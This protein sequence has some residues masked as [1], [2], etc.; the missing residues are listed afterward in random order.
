MPLKQKSDMPELAGETLWLN[1]EWKKE[2][3]IG[4][5]PTLIHFWSVSCGLC[6]EAMPKLN[7]LRDSYQNA[8]HFVSVHMPRSKRDRDIDKITKGAERNGIT[9]AVFVDND[10]LLTNA[11]Q[12]EYVPAYY[13]F[14][15]DGRLYHVQTGDDGIRLLR[16]KIERI[17][18]RS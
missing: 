6:E 9:Q 4:S 5:K 13:L 11:F 7:K 2:E 18:N 15:K 1:K 10:H 8:V 14:D 3:L 12:N 16:K 17:L